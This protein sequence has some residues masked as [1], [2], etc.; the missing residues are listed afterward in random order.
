MAHSLTNCGTCKIDFAD[1]YRYFI[2]IRYTI[3][4]MYKLP[5]VS[6]SSFYFHFVSLL[7]NGGVLVILPIFMTVV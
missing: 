6:C 4:I 2:Q 1:I 7:L 3:C 5:Q